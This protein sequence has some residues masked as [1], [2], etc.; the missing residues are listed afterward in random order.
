M[1]EVRIADERM[2][3]ARRSAESRLYRRYDHARLLTLGRDKLKLSAEEAILCD[4]IEGL[5]AAYQTVSESL[6][7]YPDDIRNGYS[8]YA[9]GAYGKSVLSRLLSPQ[10]IHR[11]LDEFSSLCPDFSEINNGGL[12]GPSSRSLVESSYFSIVKML[13]KPEE[14]TD[15]SF[16]FFDQI[17][18][19]GRALAAS[20]EMPHLVIDGLAIGPAQE[21]VLPKETFGDIIGQDEA[22][23]RIEELVSHV[24]K[25]NTR[26]CVN[27]VGEFANYVLLYGYPGMGKTSTVKAIKRKMLEVGSRNGKPVVV[28]EVDGGIK[29]KWYGNTEQA[30]IASFDA[31]RARDVIGLLVVDDADGLFPSRNL[32]GHGDPSRGPQQTL[33]SLLEGV[34][35]ENRYNHLVVFMTN[36]MDDLGEA[37]LQRTSRAQFEFARYSNEGQYERLIK[38][39]SE[40]FDRFKVKDWKAVGGYCLDN[41]LSAREV[42][43]AVTDVITTSKRYKDEDWMYSNDCDPSKVTE[44]IR[45]Q[46][47]TV[48]DKELLEALAGKVEMRRRGREIQRSSEISQMSEQILRRFEAEDLAIEALAK[49][50]GEGDG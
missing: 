12:S 28:R 45:K 42:T 29:D 44:S 40:G 37:V 22:V 8:W 48:T 6:G 35:T 39:K 16:W 26:R 33:M 36:R 5:V 47:R 43:N 2:L 23:G 21:S 41:K 7:S 4:G 18:T 15:F 14:V 11:S 1:M 38:K 30:L 13:K 32:L 10:P 49:R 17:S 31:V 9:A 34:K 25:Y 24:M 19:R 3:E 20:R 46:Y 27:P 50:M